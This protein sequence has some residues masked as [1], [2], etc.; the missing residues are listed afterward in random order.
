[1]NPAIALK[2][3]AYLIQYGPSLTEAYSEI[4]ALIVKIKTALEQ[5]GELTAEQEAQFDQ[6]IA[7][8]E[9][10]SWWQQQP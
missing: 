8:L 2:L 7:E 9:A 4:S 5:R 3:L 1:M 6:H 10:S